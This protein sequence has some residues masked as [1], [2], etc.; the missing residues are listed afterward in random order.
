MCGRTRTCVHGRILVFSMPARGVAQVERGGEPGLLDRRWAAV[1]YN[2]WTAAPAAGA[3]R[4]N[5]SVG[6]RGGPA[7]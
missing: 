6:Q 1:Y 3:S 4:Q 5:N 2:T 7:V